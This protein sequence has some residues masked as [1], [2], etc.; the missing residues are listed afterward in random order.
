[1]TQNKY[2]GFK[3]RVFFQVKNDDKSFGNINFM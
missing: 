2:Y 3:M 1:M